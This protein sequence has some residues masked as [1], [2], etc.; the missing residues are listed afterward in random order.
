M[1]N[2]KIYLALLAMSVLVLVSCQD[3]MEMDGMNAG[4]SEYMVSNFDDMGVVEIRGGT[5]EEEFVISDVYA[6]EEDGEGHFDGMGRPMMK[7][8]NMHKGQNGAKHGRGHGMMRV[9]VDMDLSDEQR[10]EIRGF[11]LSM[12]DCARANMVSLRDLNK[13]ARV[14]LREARK[15]IIDRVKAGDITRDVAQSEMK[16]LREDMRQKMQDDPERASLIEALKECRQGFFD[17]IEGILTDA[18]LEIWNAW[19]EEIEARKNG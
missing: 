10:E 12:K 14:E 15:A 3:D 16:E 5:M 9:F 8:G 13:P 4:S 18:Q 19:L 6:G 2:V 11:M 7:M 1:K 17:S